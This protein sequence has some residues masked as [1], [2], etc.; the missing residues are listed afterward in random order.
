M[1]TTHRAVRLAALLA[2]GLL[3]ACSTRYRY[4]GYVPLA[5][6]LARIEIGRD[7]RESVAEIAGT[8][9]AGG[10]LDEDGYYYVRSQ[11]EHYAF[12]AP[13]EID[14]QVLAITFTEAGVVRNIQRFG[15]EDGNVIV[16]EQ[17]V[18]DDNIPDNTFIRQLLNNIGNVQAGQLL[19]EG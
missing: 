19:G 1:T 3:A 10:V 7:T 14:R 6:D 17:R 4:H 12:Y 18:T 9:T 8:P 11:F 5:E 16:L 13:V 2:L 15:L